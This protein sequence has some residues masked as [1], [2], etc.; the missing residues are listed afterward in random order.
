MAYSQDALDN[1]RTDL[2]KLNGN[3]EELLLSY[4][5]HDYKKIKA[6]EFALQGFTR[7]L[8]TITLALQKVFSLIPPEQIKP[9]IEEVRV[10]T[11]IHIQAFLINT[12]GCLDN[13]AWVWAIETSLKESNGTPISRRRIGLGPQNTLMRHSLSEPFQAR[14]CEFN[15]WFN[16]MKEYRDALAHRIPLYI[17]PY[18]VTKKNIEQYEKIDRRMKKA[19]S[20]LALDEYKKLNKEQENLGVFS[21]WMTHSFDET[22]SPIFFHG[23]LLCDY[24]TVIELGRLMI[25][26]LNN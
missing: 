15:D 20:Q 10:E 23:Q 21:G 8:K 17:V 9:P 26:E 6:K 5:Q 18:V 19:F 4:F 2:A 1:M 12:A 7:R 25:E 22:R 14:L 13:L 11:A 24:L 3:Y 16:L